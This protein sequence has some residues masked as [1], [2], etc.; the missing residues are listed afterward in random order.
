MPEYTLEIMF[1]NSD[2]ET[3]AVFKSHQPFMAIHVGDTI[4]PNIWGE[5]MREVLKVTKLEHIIW[6]LSGPRHKI[7]VYTVAVAA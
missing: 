2:T 7:L 3:M 6:D 4:N 5:D 1:P